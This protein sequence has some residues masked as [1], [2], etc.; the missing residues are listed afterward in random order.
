VVVEPFS[1][2]GTPFFNLDQVVTE[3]FLGI[4]RDEP[5]VSIVSN[6]STV[7]SLGDKLLY[8]RP[9]HGSLWVVV[10]RGN[11]V[12]FTSKIVCQGVLTHFVI[13]IVERVFYV[14]TQSLELFALDK[15]RMEP[16]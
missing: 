8:S 3:D 10:L 4:C 2:L 15:N 7:V 6:T 1:A 13:R 16:A 14:P 12:N 11:F 9:W 5:S